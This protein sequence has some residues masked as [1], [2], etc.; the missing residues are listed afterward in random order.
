MLEHSR[1]SATPLS[2]RSDSGPDT[3]RAPRRRTEVPSA[4]QASPC[5]RF[6][7]PDVRGYWWR[8]DL[9]QTNLALLREHAPV[10]PEVVDRQSVSAEQGK[11]PL[12]VVAN[13]NQRSVAIVRD[14]GRG[15]K[16]HLW[17]IV[18]HKRGQENL[19]AISSN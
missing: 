17:N 13:N 9:R 8:F 14:V 2:R 6:L 12:L 7:V 15:I 4:E 10:I 18:F 1:V 16:R 3:R 5:G 19:P 11:E